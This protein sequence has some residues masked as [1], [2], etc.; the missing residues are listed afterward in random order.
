M[1]ELASFSRL[2]LFDRRGVGLS[3]R[4]SG[5]PPLE[6]RMDDVRAVMDA[7]GSD[8]AALF[9]AG[10]DGAMAALFAATYP[11]RVTALVLF[12]VPPRGLWAPD[13]PWGR[14]EDEARQLVEEAERRFDD[15][16]LLRGL[17]Q[18]LYPTV[19]GD[20]EVIAWA[21]RATRLSATPSTLAA[22]R[23]ISKSTSDPCC[24]RFVYLPS[25]SIATAIVTCPSA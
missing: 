25:S 15:P 1:R 18:R 9:G 3:D 24:R 23:Q 6:Q 16:D 17:A 10:P 12:A 8:R 22:L 4:P 21:M 13:Y 11:E 14:R 19:A 20:D 2:L 5:V 7:V